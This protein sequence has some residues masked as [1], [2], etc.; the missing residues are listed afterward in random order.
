MR[1]FQEGLRQQAFNNRLSL[2]TA[3]PLS[4]NSANALSSQRMSG[5]SQTQ[6]ST[7]TLGFGQVASGIGGGLVG[8]GLGVN[9]MRG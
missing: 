6:N 1:Q 9:A 3:A 5:M 2:S 7:N 4:F 8:L